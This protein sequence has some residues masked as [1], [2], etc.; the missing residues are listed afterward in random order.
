[1]KMQ[2][3]AGGV[4][5][6]VGVVAAIG[7]FFYLKNKGAAVAHA[8][9]PLNQENIFNKSYE[10]LLGGESNAAMYSDKAFAMLDLVNPFNASDDYAKQTLGI[11]KVDTGGWLIPGVVRTPPITQEMKDSFSSLLDWLNPF[12]DSPAAQQNLVDEDYRN[13]VNNNKT[14]Y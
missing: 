6:I 2:I 8:V 4:V 1:M 14:G 10:Q 12:N 5:A 13:T 7:A 3:S 9:N 11:D